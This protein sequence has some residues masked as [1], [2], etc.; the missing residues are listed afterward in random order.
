MINMIEN[1]N[2]S[3]P[4]NFIYDFM[5][6]AEY[7][8]GELLTEYNPQYNPRTTDFYSIDKSKLLRYGYIGSGLR[9][10]FN[11]YDGIFN[12]NNS[13][14]EIFFKYNN[15]LYS[16]TNMLGVK[17]NDII[18]FKRRTAYFNPLTGESCGSMNG[19]IDSY[20]IG[21]KSKLYIGNIEFSVKAI[22]SIQKNEL[23]L[24]QIKIVPNQDFQNCEVVIRK[25][26]L[27]EYNYPCNM[28]SNI[29]G[30]LQWVV[31]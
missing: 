1:I 21:W 6:I 14:Y 17:Y 30:E 10:Y 25:D 31:R 12:I 15:Q 22:Y 24:L 8:D 19:N 29:G 18:Q 7:D 16:L 28:K 3:T 2:D 20:N 9:V 5:W 4:S 27:I 11:V 23:P 13:T 26:R